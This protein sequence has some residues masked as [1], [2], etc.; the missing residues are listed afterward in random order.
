[1]LAVQKLHVH[2]DVPA[3]PRAS[4]E[5]DRVIGARI[6]QR[7]T[8]LKL[9]QEKLA[10]L[11]GVTFQQ[12]QKYEKGVN[13]VS[14]ATLYRIAQQLQLPTSEL[15]PVGSDRAQAV[16]DLTLRCLAELAADLT[17][18]GQSLLVDLAQTLARCE[19]LRARVQR[20]AQ[21]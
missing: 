5:I 21:I 15:L 18:E 14:A 3:P 7:R 1:M 17:V 20:S 11:I 13:R 9:S 12:I 4:T 8:A 2:C 10:E 19:R 16:D 6:R